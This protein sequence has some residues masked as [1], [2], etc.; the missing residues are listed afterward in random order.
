MKCPNCHGHTLTGCPRCPHCEQLL[1]PTFM[2]IESHL[3]KAIIATLLCC[4]PTGIIAIVQACRVESLLAKGE[5]KKAIEASQSADR[6]V[7][8]SILLGFIAFVLSSFVHYSF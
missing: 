4:P 1:P 2:R 8:I 5:R 6:W 3:I 7:S